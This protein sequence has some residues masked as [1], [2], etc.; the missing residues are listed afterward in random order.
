VE[1]LGYA[2]EAAVASLLPLLISQD[3]WIRLAAVEALGRIG[4]SRAVISLVT[5]LEDESE[6]VRKAAADALTKIG[7][8][9]GLQALERAYQ[10]GRL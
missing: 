3:R 8:P 6:G 9:S 7:D 2:G 10:E 4:S 1:A 5:R